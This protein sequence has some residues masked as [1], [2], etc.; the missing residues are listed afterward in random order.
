MTV[1]EAAREGGL[2]GACEYESLASEGGAGLLAPSSLRDSGAGPLFA[3]LLLLLLG[4]SSLSFVLSS[5]AP[6]RRA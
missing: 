6:S 4:L 3:L 5:G 1:P 2:L